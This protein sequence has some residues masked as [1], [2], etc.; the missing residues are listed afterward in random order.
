[1][2]VC[3]TTYEGLR[4]I[5]LPSTKLRHLIRRPPAQLCTN[6]P[7]ERVLYAGNY[8]GPLLTYGSLYLSV[9]QVYFR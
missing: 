3:R 9:L 7:T 2:A 6:R 1:M 4:L 8:V 5:L